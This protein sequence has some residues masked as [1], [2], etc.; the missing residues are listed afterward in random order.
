VDVTG[1]LGLGGCNCIVL[2]NLFTVFCLVLPSSIIWFQCKSCDS[3]L[4]LLKRHD[5]LYMYV[6]SPPAQFAVVA[7]M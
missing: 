1:G 5:L 7:E 6:C 2:G 3:R 4:S